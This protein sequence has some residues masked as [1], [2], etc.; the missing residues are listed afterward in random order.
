MSL[1]LKCAHLTWVYYFI[2]LL[3]IGNFS[4]WR[5]KT[6]MA[7]GSGQELGDRLLMDIN[8]YTFSQR[9]MEVYLLIKSLIYKTGKQKAKLNQD[10]WLP[11]IEKFREDMIIYLETK[12]L[13]RFQ[14]PDDKV[15]SIARD[16]ERKI[17]KSTV[18]RADASR[19]GLDRLTLLRA[20][21]SVVQVEE[22]RKLKSMGQEPSWIK[23]LEPKYVVRL[24][25]GSH[26][27][28]SI[29]PNRR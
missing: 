4:P 28:Q 26:R 27:Y 16:L 29:N 12:R 21:A 2:G 22:Y 17:Y 18:I 3:L 24:F 1:S 20:V 6:A 10:N 15:Q 11:S 9:Q 8:H 19:L 14:P 13:G 5:G 23:A 25:K 7:Q